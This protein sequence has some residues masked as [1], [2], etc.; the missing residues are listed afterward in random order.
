MLRL[1][2]FLL[3][4]LHHVFFRDPL[5]KQVVHT[6][7]TDAESNIANACAFGLCLF[8]FL[9]SY[10]ITTLLLI[11]LGET[12]GINVKEFY[13]R[14]VLR[15]WPLYIVGLSIGMIYA[16]VYAAPEQFEMLCYYVAFLGNWFYQNH[17]WGSN[18]MTPLWSISV[19][20]QF[21]LVLPLFVLALGTTRLIWGGF[22]V[23]ILSIAALYYQGEQHLSVDTAIWTNTLSHS[24]FFGSGIIAAVITFERLP[25]LNIR[26]RLVAAAVA[27][28]FMF[29]SASVFKAR[30]AEYASS[31]PAIVFGYVLV[32][33]ACALLLIS[34]LNSDV[35]FPA[36]IVYLGKI[37]FG[38]YVYHTLGMRIA[39]RVFSPG[40]SVP[41]PSVIAD[42]CS[43]PLLVLYAALSYRY[44]E[45]PFLRLKTKFTYVASRPD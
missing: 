11:E 25:K 18:L 10:L 3:V 37:S 16:L 31:G 32:A 39:E 24:I 8:Y 38:L 34:L 28:I 44:I 14:R 17:D 22:G 45:A 6:I 19:E 43:L 9:S 4:F 33:V 26:A 41:I 12:D 5:A 42:F 15:I 35:T 23:V 7:A 29:L 1:V 2:A 40:A 27:F 13:L 30:A 21:Y 20:E 36:P